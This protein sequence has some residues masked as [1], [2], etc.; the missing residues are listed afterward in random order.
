MGKAVADSEIV[1]V[2]LHYPGHLISL[3]GHLMEN[4]TMG[5][6]AGGT[7]IETIGVEEL[8]TETT[9][10]EEAAS[11]NVGKTQDWVL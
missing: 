11:I 4:G 6:E 2:D 8:T 7:T 1:A 3:K 9:K 10:V 5:G